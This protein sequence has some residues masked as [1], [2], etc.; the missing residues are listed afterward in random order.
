[1]E[2]LTDSK[3]CGLSFLAWH[4]LMISFIMMILKDVA[5]AMLILVIQNC[6]ISKWFSRL[7]FQYS[8][9]LSDATTKIKVETYRFG[10]QEKISN[11]KLYFV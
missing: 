8:S 10:F 3:P 5:T 11:I 2:W 7:P 9:I 6:K 4:M 1:M